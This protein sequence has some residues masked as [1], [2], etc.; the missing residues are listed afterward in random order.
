MLS[1][2]LW[3]HLIPVI[4]KIPFFRNSWKISL[5][6]STENNYVERFFFM[7][8]ENVRS[9][10]LKN[11]TVTNAFSF[12]LNFLTYQVQSSSFR[13]VCVFF[14]RWNLVLEFLSC[15][16]FWRDILSTSRCVFY[17]YLSPKYISGK[18]RKLH[19]ETKTNKQE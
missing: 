3:A 14:F 15:D 8:R 1:F 5:V 16:L 9:S 6:A 11:S 17:L 10:F 18:R 19:F 7:K 2:Y 13:H 4:K 12:Q